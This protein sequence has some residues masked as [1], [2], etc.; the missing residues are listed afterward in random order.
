MSFLLKIV[1]GPNKGAE[2]ALVEG[3]AVTLGKT[4]ACDIVLADATL[5]DEPIEIEASADGVTF[6]GERLEP[7]HV[8]VRGSTA[9]AVGPSDSPWGELV[10][11]KRESSPERE[12]TEDSGSRE[13]GGGERGEPR[14]SGPAPEKSEGKRRSCLGCLIAS[15]LLLLA[16]AILAWLF[17]GWLEPRV[18]ELLGRAGH[19]APQN[20]VDTAT[21]HDAVGGADSSKLD[22]LSPLVKRYGLATTNR[23]GR[24]ILVGDFATR[25]ERLA[26]TAEA[27]AAQPGVELDFAD[28]ESLKTAVADTLALVGETAMGVSAVTGRVAVLTGK[29]A[30]LKQALEAISAEVPKLANFDVSGVHVTPLAVMVA[31]GTANAEPSSPLVPSRSAAVARREELGKQETVAPSLPVCGILTT[32][33]PCLVLRDGRRIMEGAPVGEWTVLKIGADSVTI[34]NAVGRFTWKP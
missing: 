11:P 10:W 18:N 7:L 14:D 22:P 20:A 2:I 9:F 26:A 32:P 33:Y 16:L 6:G 29:T 3:V 30:K 4:D 12:E 13:A 23:N 17:R 5:G 27:Y 28:G 15:I 25:A 21:S 24:A 31:P 34:T 8:A 1:E 19:N